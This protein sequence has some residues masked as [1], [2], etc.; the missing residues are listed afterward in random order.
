MPR[1]PYPDIGA[2]S[3]AVQDLFAQLPVKLNI[4]RMTA[5][6]EE[7]CPALLQLGGKILTA[8]KLSPLL[9]ELAILRVAQLSDAEYEWVQHVPMA[10]A[11]GVSAGQ[12]E[13]LKRGERTGH[14]FTVEEAAVLAFTDEVLHNVRPSDESLAAARE[15]LSDQEV[16]E[17]TCAIGFYMLMARIMEVTGVDV[18]GPAAQQVLDAL[19]KGG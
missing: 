6:L 9:R 4:L 17:L 5:H 19:V 3:D 13:A 1:M 14:C 11:A 16:V 15:A 18:D 8:Q 12:I 10:E 2:A 7:S